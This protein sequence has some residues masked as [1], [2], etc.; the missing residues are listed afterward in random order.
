MCSDGWDTPECEIDGEC[1]DCG[2]PTTEGVLLVAATP[3]Q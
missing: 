2:E 1:P 3:H